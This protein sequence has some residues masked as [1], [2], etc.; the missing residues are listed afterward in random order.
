MG[1]Y[2]WSQK[3]SLHS[4][5]IARHLELR[6]CSKGKVISEVKEKLVKLGE[7]HAEE[8]CSLEGEVKKA[9]D[10]Y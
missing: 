4:C 10:K 2:S 8:I 9:E 1:M 3:V 7:T 6:E 5:A